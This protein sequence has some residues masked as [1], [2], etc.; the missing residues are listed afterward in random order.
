MLQRMIVSGGEWV[1][2]PGPPSAEA[3]RQLRLRLRNMCLLGKSFFDHGFSVVLDDIIIGERWQHLQEELQGYPFSLVV[4][5]PS[6]EVVRVRDAAR[7]KPPLGARWAEYL[8]AE[9]RNT[10]TG[11]GTW[12]DSSDQTPE[13][14]VDLI[15]TRCFGV[16]KG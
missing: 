10:M 7:G 1:G 11:I 4:L 9:L 13:E 16:G 6:T 3:G 12:I 5:A 2:E 15:L 14:T 8:D